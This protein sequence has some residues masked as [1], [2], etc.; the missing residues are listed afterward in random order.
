[1]LEANRP[2]VRRQRTCS[3]RIRSPPRALHPGRGPRRSGW[4]ER[5]ER[6]R[7]PPRRPEG[8]GPEGGC[9]AARRRRPSDSGPGPPPHPVRQGPRA[10]VSRD[11]PTKTWGGL[12]KVLEE[13]GLR[14]GWLLAGWVEPGT[15][16]PAR[17]ARSVPRRRTAVRHRPELPVLARAEGHLAEMHSQRGPAQARLEQPA[18]A[19]YSLTG[20][21]PTAPAPRSGSN[22]DLSAA[23]RTSRRNR[24]CCSSTS[25]ASRVVNDSLGHRRGGERSSS[26]TGRGG[27]SPPRSASTGHSSGGFGGASHRVAGRG[28][29][30]RARHG[31]SPAPPGRPWTNPVTAH[32][33]GGVASCPPPLHRASR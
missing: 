29:Q 32:G 9:P 26:N 8:L 3:R 6:R 28:R 4:L 17:P 20:T 11:L 10:V 16:H 27:G 18:P 2:P 24:S 13:V 30:R 1:L 15:G 25:D 14:T 19:N 5:T 31:P 22:A 33:R 21:S 7:S 23:R 12:A